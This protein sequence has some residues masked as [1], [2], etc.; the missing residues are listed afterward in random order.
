MSSKT[1]VDPNSIVETQPNV[2]ISPTLATIAVVPTIVSFTIKF[3]VL[4]VGS[5]LVG[6]AFGFFIT[7][8]F[9]GSVI[10]PGSLGFWRTASYNW[11]EIFNNGNYLFTGKVFNDISM[12]LSYNFAI[13]TTTPIDYMWRKIGKNWYPVNPIHEL[14]HISI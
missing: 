12:Q 5:F 7:I 2:I 13:A 8:E 11:K 9:V 4:L 10:L 1:A 3:P 14:F 6:T